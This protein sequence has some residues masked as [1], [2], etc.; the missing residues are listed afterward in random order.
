MCIACAAAAAAAAAAGSLK[1]LDAVV[2][3]VLRLHPTYGNMLTREA[4]KDVVLGKIKVMPL[5]T[6]SSGTG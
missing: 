2:R 6:G 4:S 1:Y 3:E 5:A